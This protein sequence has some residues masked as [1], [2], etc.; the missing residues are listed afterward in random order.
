MFTA[1][2]A[3]LGSAYGTPS[4]DAALLR[5]PPKRGLS[6]TGAYRAHLMFK[7][8][9]IFMI[10]DWRRPAWV[11]TSAHL[12]PGGSEGF[13]RFADLIEGTLPVSSVRPEVIGS[14]GAPAASRRESP[15]PSGPLV[16][17]PWDRY[18]YFT[19]SVRF[20]YA[21]PEGPIRLVTLMSPDV[22]LAL[23][24][25]MRPVQGGAA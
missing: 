5:L 16:L 20:E 11:F 1:L 4:I 8:H 15:T 13:G 10:F 9:G 22:A 6:K 21:S 3:A 12:Y 19:H 2:V 14:F 17:F 25:D 24:P 18:D 7:R 23:N